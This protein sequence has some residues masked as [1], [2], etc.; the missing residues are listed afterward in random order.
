MGNYYFRTHSIEVVSEG[1]ATL[2]KILHSNASGCNDA[3]LAVSYS[4]SDICVE[5]LINKMNSKFSDWCHNTHFAHNHGN[6]LIS[7]IFS[8]ACKSKKIFEPIKLNTAKRRLFKIRNF[9]IKEANNQTQ[10]QK[11]KRKWAPK[12]IQC[13]VDAITYYCHT[14]KD[15]I[16][17]I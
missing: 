11:R 7:Y 8:N 10:T 14:A 15:T 6:N 4:G 5:N 17:K 3:T 16:F 12:E 13:L 9:I 2:I 1:F